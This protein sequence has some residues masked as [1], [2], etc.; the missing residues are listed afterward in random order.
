VV[1][2]FD[3]DPARAGAGELP[4]PH[5]IKRGNT[6][7]GPV[8]GQAPGTGP[9]SQDENSY[10]TVYAREPGSAAA[11]TAGLHFT[12]RVLSRLREKN[13]SWNEITLHVG[14]GTFRPVKTTDVRE[15]RMHEERF[16]IP[17]AVATRIAETHRTSHRVL[18]VGTTTV[19]T[20]ESAGL[21]GGTVRAGEGRTSLFIHPGTYEF[22]IVDRMLTNFHLPKSTLLMMVSTFAGRE[23]VLAAYAEA[24]REKYRFFSYGDAMLIL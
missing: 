5:D 3:R 1:A 22:K 14:L 10:Q 2:K 7:G 16:F 17:E 23:L 24:V 12:D 4:L 8:A 15:H 13:V 21:A 6:W 20:L 9:T 18:A 11:P 19:R